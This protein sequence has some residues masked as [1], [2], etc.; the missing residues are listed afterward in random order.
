M[1]IT[2]KP[3]SDYE[4]HRPEAERRIAARDPD[5]CPTVALA[6]KRDPLISRKTM[7]SPTPASKS[8]GL[9]SPVLAC[10]QRGMGALS[11][12]S[13]VPKMSTLAKR[14]LRNCAFVSFSGRV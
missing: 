12:C 4:D 5:D 2:W 8:S 3:A 7:T 9:V 14:R 6:L 1:P 10:P 13:Q 11:E